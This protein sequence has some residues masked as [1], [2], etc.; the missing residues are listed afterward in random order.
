MLRVRF[1]GTSSTYNAIV[2]LSSYG[3]VG[4]LAYRDLFPLGVWITVKVVYG[5]GGTYSFLV[6]DVLLYKG[7]A[8]IDLGFYFGKGSSKVE[9]DVGQLGTPLLAGYVWY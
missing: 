1:S 8:C 5:T 4:R 2:A 3:L 9:L 7:T 6:N